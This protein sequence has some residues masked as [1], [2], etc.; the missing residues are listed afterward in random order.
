M[1]R[2]LPIILT[3]IA[4]LLIAA[5]LAAAKPVARATQ[6]TLLL[7]F[8]GPL[9]GAQE[10]N[11][12]D[13]LRGTQ[14]A[15]NEINKAGGVLGMKIKLITADDKAN[16]T[17]GVSVAKALIKK[18]PYAVIGPYNSSVGVQNL[19]L[20]EKAGVLPVQL[21]STDETTGMG[22]TVQ[23]KNSQ[24]SPVEVDWIMDQKPAKVTILSDDTEDFTEGMSDRMQK[25]LTKQGVLVS[26][27]AIDPTQ[28][29]FTAAVQQGLANNP[30]VV[31]VSTY[32]P[33]GSKIATA[34]AASGTTSKCFMGLA[35]QDPAFIKQA[36]VAAASRCVFSGTPTPSQFGNKKAK[37]Y[38]SNY[39]KAFGKTPGT[40][41]I[42]TYDS[43][44][45]LAN[46]IRRGGA[47]D[48]EAT[49]YAILRTQN[50][51]GATGPITIDRKTGNRPNVPIAI[52]GVDAT[53]GTF[54][55]EQI[56]T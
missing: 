42:Y 53:S 43:V 15:V 7:G 27:I 2:R 50:L 45:L 23:P 8:E 31:Y 18:N 13:M 3:A 25:A 46:A 11:G 12:R 38:V 19:P 4:A 34:L 47:I 48:V 36:G 40:W 10:A 22:V 49:T 51:A 6:G 29:D 14:L 33:Q 32:Y 20:Y 44:Y 41:G 24:I 17:T 54:V 55:I 56:Y 26:R 30:T 9:S 37:A 1:R 28:T 5:P 16:A 21:T 52:L 39:S 35:N